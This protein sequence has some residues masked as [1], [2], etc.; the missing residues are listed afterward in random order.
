MTFTGDHICGIEG[1]EAEVGREVE[2]GA[3][4][5]RLQ[6]APLRAS[7]LRWP[8]GIAQKLGLS[9]QL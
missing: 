5:Q 3:P 7:G 2:L 9:V 4:Q 6:L 8:F 1:T